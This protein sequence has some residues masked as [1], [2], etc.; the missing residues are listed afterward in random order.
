MIEQ[1]KDSG[2][3][4]KDCRLSEKPRRFFVISLRLF[5]SFIVLFYGF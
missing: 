5:N 1:F 4:E 2:V 3:F